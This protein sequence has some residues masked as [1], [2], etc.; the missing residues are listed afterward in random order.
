M[1]E[2]R[3]VK[4]SVAMY[5]DTKFK[6]I[7]KRTERDLIHYVWNRVMVLAGKTNQEGDLY[8]SRT[9]PYTVET[10]AIEFNRGTEEVKL[11]L[12]VLIELEMVEFTE[13]CVYRVKNFAKHQNIKVKEKVIVKDKEVKLKNK[14]VQV[15]EVSR[16]VKKEETSNLEVIQ[17]TASN[18]DDNITKEKVNSNSQDSIPIFLEVKNNKRD[19][20]KNKID[21]ILE[22]S[23]DNQI[24]GIHN[25][26]RPLGEGE[27]IMMEFSMCN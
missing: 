15:A 17:K 9:I 4:V 27:R 13:D 6:I 19:N 2:R 20:K 8:M 3:Y 25:K 5:D 14:D 22:E 16:N 23:E 18:V 11:A 26:E 24:D 7:D 21:E 10:L 1:R 12:E